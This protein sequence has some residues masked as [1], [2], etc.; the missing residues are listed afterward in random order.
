MRAR[1]SISWTEIRDQLKK[2]FA[3]DPQTLEKYDYL[4]PEVSCKCNMLMHI[5]SCMICR[6][7]LTLMK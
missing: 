2:N 5:L 3:M 1:L 6:I 4:S 7:L